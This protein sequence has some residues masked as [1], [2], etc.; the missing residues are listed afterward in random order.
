MDQK[1]DI[2]E[3]SLELFIQKGCKS[4]TMDDIARENGIS[5]RTLYELFTDKHQLLEASLKLMYEQM[6]AQIESHKNRY[7]NVID[8]MFNIHS[9]QSQNLLDLK[10]HFFEELSRYYY[11][12]Y[13]NAIT[14]FLDFHWN[15]TYGFLVKGQR[16]GLIREDI[17]KELVTKVMIE[18]SNII[19]NSEFF[20]LKEYSRRELFKT[21]VLSY[22][23]GISTLKG[24]SL[25]DENIK[26]MI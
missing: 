19:E 2:I 23:R 10:K 15:M 12:V 21:I 11:P 7:D 1:R 5:K 16:E 3:R 20:P 8:A 9:E 26:K 24:I 14:Y 6:E 13:K 4:V 18:I 22:I 25:I 17:D